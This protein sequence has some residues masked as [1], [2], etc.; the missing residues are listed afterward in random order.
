MWNVLMPLSNVSSQKWTDGIAFKASAHP[1][2][3]S[4]FLFVVCVRVCASL[5]DVRALL[6]GL[7]S[8]LTVGAPISRLHFSLVS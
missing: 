4:P 2:H 5:D 8:R 3:F 7:S 6:F 1:W